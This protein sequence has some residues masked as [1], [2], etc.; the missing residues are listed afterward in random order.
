ML[1]LLRVKGIN[2]NFDHLD[3]L[4][5]YFLPLTV[6]PEIKAKPKITKKTE[7]PLKALEWA[8][9]SLERYVKFKTHDDIDG[10][11]GIKL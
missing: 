4:A 5:S 1:L 11:V 6:V 7:V 10:R 3:I 8:L 9:Q 2:S